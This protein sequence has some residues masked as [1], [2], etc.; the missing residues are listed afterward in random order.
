MTVPRLSHALLSRHRRPCLRPGHC[1]LPVLAV[2]RPAWPPCPHCAVRAQAEAATTR[3]LQAKIRHIMEEREAVK[4]LLAEQGEEL[5]ALRRG[6]AQAQG[7]SAAAH[8]VVTGALSTG[9][10]GLGKLLGGKP[11]L[12]E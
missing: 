7:A 1:P 3:E 12:G 2:L 5:Q 9:R 11:A 10:A 6:Q 8:A 4:A